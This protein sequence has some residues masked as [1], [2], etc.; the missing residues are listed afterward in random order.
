[1][2]LLSPAGNIEKLRAVY[3]YGADAAYMG[4]SSFSL[5]RHA[6]AADHNEAVQLTELKSRF[7]EKKLYCALNKFFHGPDLERLEGS[8]ELLK[9]YPFDA[10][11]LSDIGL[12]SMLKKHFPDTP[13]HLSTQANCTNAEAAK[14]YES[15]GFS[16]IILAREVGLDEIK[17]MKDVNPDLELEAFVHGAM[18]IAYSGRCLLS[19]YMVGRSG[20]QGDCSHSC[21][22]DYKV[23][24]E[25]E[26]PGEY[27]PIEQ[28][29]DFTAIMSSRDLN[30]I[31]HI[32]LFQDA[33]VD[34]LKI[35]GRMK[36]AYY[37]AI[38]TRSYRRAIEKLTDDSID[39]KPY[40]DE[41]DRVSHREWS[42]GFYFDKAE[43][44]KVTDRSYVQEFQFLGRIETTE[45]PG[46]FSVAP[47]NRIF[48]DKDLEFIGPDILTLTDNTYKL[49]DEDMNE[50]DLIH[51]G[52]P[53]FIRTDLPL[54]DGYFIREKK[55]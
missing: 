6:G 17:H 12:V 5:R 20:N 42:T 28:G 25:K 53:G 31:E 35:E 48:L 32:K 41:L 15:M 36:S 16:R 4:F 26:R 21:R 44:S 40:I 29:D 24:E 19:S 30:M 2:E 18:C 13:L 33:G 11:I 10:F 50:V 22:W 46:L 51:H 45:T 9:E 1:M 54:K 3:E 37:A 7:G 8:L 55:A 39:L 43:A 23:L 52:K 14:L 47:K 27:F 34:S 38:V 49:F